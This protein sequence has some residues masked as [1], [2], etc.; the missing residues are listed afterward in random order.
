LIG[1]LEEKYESNRIE[2]YWLME[3]KIPY[4][5]AESEMKFEYY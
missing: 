2:K 1:L 3:A 5:S 4:N